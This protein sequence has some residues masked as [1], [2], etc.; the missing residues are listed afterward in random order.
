M[1][2]TNVDVM[3]QLKAMQEQL[4]AMRPP[5]PGAAP[6][7]MQ[8]GGVSFGPGPGPMGPMMGQPM[9]APNFG[10]PGMTPA[11][12]T[13]LLVA[14]SVPT[15]QGEVT[16]H[17]QFGGDAAANPQAVIMSLMQQGWPV[18]AYQRNGGGGWGGGGGGGGF[19]RG[20]GFRRGGW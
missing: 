19:N 4:N 8:M 7:P 14:I 15:P 13:G 16:C 17:L 10:G 11:Q 6:V 9:G 1:A 20:G 18:K 2:E 12:P 3:Q 5:Q